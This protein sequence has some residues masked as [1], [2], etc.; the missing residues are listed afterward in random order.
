MLFKPPRPEGRKNCRLEG[1]PRDCA[2]GVVG[3]LGYSSG[4]S[5]SGMLVTRCDQIID[6]RVGRERM[7]RVDCGSCGAMQ[8]GDAR[9]IMKNS[10]DR[11]DAS[12]SCYTVGIVIFVLGGGG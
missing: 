2:S 3:L 10:F 5:G 1:A 8:F 7:H 4:L 9:W 6:I 12:G 11:G